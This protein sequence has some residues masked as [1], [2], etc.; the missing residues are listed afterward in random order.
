MYVY[1]NREQFHLAEVPQGLCLDY[2]CALKTGFLQE[3]SAK[4]WYEGWSNRWIVLQDDYLSCYENSPRLEFSGQFKLRKSRIFCYEVGYLFRIVSRSGTSIE[5][6]VKDQES[7]NMWLEKF[8]EVPSAQVTRHKDLIENSPSA[9]L[10]MSDSSEIRDG[11]LGEW[12]HTKIEGYKL[13]LDE[14]DVQYAAF[15]VQV[16]SSSSGNSVVQ[17]RYS[18]F[19]ALH[20]EL[21][22]VIPHEQVPALPGTRMWNKFDPTYLKEKT[23]GLHGY[24]TEVCKR[25]ANTR[26]QP[27][28]LEFLEL[29]PQTATNGTDV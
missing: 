8:S 20:R 14:K 15:V 21:R 3:K 27:L 23:V 9:V 11:A 17:R 2:F 28:L 24:L 29:S 13:S 5:M 6:R 26:A 22:K 4:G 7:F 19:A 25:C 16:K 1:V 10:I 18:E 12:L